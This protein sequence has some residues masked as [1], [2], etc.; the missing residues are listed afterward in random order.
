MSRCPRETRCSTAVRAPPMLSIRPE[1]KVSS[2]AYASTRT[3]GGAAWR[4]R[5]SLRE[6]RAHDHKTVAA[7]DLV[8]MRGSSSG[9]WCWSTGMV[10]SIRFMC[11]SADRSGCPRSPGRRSVRLL[12]AAM[13]RV[14]HQA[15]RIGLLV[16]ARRARHRLIAERLAA[17]PR[18]RG[19]FETPPAPQ[20]QRNGSGREP[21]GGRHLRQR[22]R[23]RSASLGH[24]SP[25][26]RLEF[27]R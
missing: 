19:G 14:D 17:R 26:V 24:G 15:D 23:L 25:S 5:G 22:N 16:L 11:G 9:Y 27:Q 10:A 3:A 4:T 20:G 8:T 13:N 7:F 1:S 18:A 6:M 21:D 12:G 2:S